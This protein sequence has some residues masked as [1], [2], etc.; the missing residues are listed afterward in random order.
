MT[1]E[2]TLDHLPSCPCPAHMQ[3][4]RILQN[5][6]SGAGNIPYESQSCF[7]GFQ[8]TKLPTR[9]PHF[10]DFNPKYMVRQESLTPPSSLA[11][12]SKRRIYETDKNTAR[13]NPSPKRPKLEKYPITNLGSNGSNMNEEYLVTANVQILN[14]QRRHEEG[15]EKYRMS[16][17]LPSSKWGWGSGQKSLPLPQLMGFKG[18]DYYDKCILQQK[19]KTS[20]RLA[21]SGVR[22]DQE[23]AAD[24]QLGSERFNGFS[25]CRSIS[26]SPKSTPSPL[27]CLT[28]VHN[29]SPVSVTRNMS[30]SI[31]YYSHEIG[32]KCVSIPNGYSSPSPVIAQSTASFSALAEASSSDSKPPLRCSSSY[33]SSSR[34]MSPFTPPSAS[35]P[36]Q[37][38]EQPI[39]LSCKK[40][41]RKMALQQS[42]SGDS[43]EG[44]G[45]GLGLL[46]MPCCQVDGS[47]LKVL[48][49][50]YK[51][52]ST[53]SGPVTETYRMAEVKVDTKLKPSQIPSNTPVTLAKKN[54]QPVSSRV[55][56]W[57]TKT[58]Q[59][60]NSL[61][62]FKR[63]TIRDKAG[64]INA[65]WARLVLLFMSE[66]NFQFVVTPHYNDVSDTASVASSSSS[67][68]S[69]C[70]CGNSVNQDTPTVGRVEEIERVIQ[71]FR[72]LGLNSRTFD[73]LRTAVLF[74]TGSL[75]L[76]DRDHIEKIY[77]SVFQLLREDIGTTGPEETLKYTRL[78]MALP[79]LLSVNVRVIENLF[80][81]QLK[82]S[83][84]HLE[85]LLRSLLT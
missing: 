49:E 2:A 33:S 64:L 63:L 21:H 28:P 58:F 74:H 54:L 47:I 75:E 32:T 70:Q 45:D 43:V 41:N 56:D 60:A 14:N 26:N 13:L 59:F 24:I 82:C 18:M 81:G 30:P 40:A 17:P 79:S 78:L 52:P 48:L 65:S 50:R 29:G 22:I 8:A 3:E 71:K 66:N 42:T 16:N 53:C 12:S 35:L 4:P 67:S 46:N 9:S 5:L 10:F 38:T 69:S 85:D 77:Q 83:N 31:R 34:S 20:L 57:V 73:L 15:E 72:N 61:E 27:G 80:C 39:D 36:I 6:L 76:T 1:T 68:C 23:T 84:T 55:S 37:E 19:G 44:F 7:N 62:N 51:K 25:E 11:A